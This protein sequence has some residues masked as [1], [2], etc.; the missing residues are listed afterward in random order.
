LY[1][2]FKAIDGNFCLIGKNDYL[3]HLF[4]ATNLVSVL[5]LFVDHDHAVKYVIEKLI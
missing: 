4:K 5:K 2:H 3:E 1:T